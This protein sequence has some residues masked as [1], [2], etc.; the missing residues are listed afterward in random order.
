MSEKTS[1]QKYCNCQKSSNKEILKSNISN[2]FCKKCGTILLKSSDGNICYPLH[3]K[4]KKKFIDFN[5]IEIIK[6]MKEKTEKDYPNIYNLYNL[7]N[8]TDETKANKPMRAINMYL[9]YRSSLIVNLQKMMKTFDYCDIVFYQTLFYL[10]TY[11]SHD[12][13]LEMSEKSIFY[14][15]VGYF[16][17]SLKSKE[18]D[19]YEPSFDSFYDIEKGMFLSP[20]KI[21]LYEV[22]CLKRI[23]YNIFNYSSYDW[24]MQ[25]I[26]IGIVFNSEVDNTNEIILI[27][28]HRHSLINT[29]NKSVI[30]ILLN[31]TIKEAFFKYSPMHVAFSVIQLTREKYIK[32]SMIKPKL[33]FKLIE[34]YGVQ[35]S[36]YQDCYEELKKIIT[37]ED[38]K[39]NIEEKKEIKNKKEE[40]DMDQ[41]KRGSL[42]KSFIN[43]N[44]K[45]NI[46]VPN[47]MRSSNANVYIN[48]NELLNM[49]KEEKEINKNKENN[50]TR[51]IISI[52]KNHLSIDCSKNAYKRNDTLPL[53][54]INTSGVNKSGEKKIPNQKMSKV[55]KFLLSLE[56]EE[57]KQGKNIS[58]NK[59]EEGNIMN[60]IRLVEKK[61]LTSTKLPKINLD[62][63]ASNKAYKVEHHKD[64]EKTRKHY[65]LK[66]TNNNFEKK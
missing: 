62:E 3:Q 23:K 39:K 34:L 21:A 47:K 50:K 30:K 18:N 31:I 48:Q 29:I 63:I 64:G 20:S 4:Q 55:D 37:N 14:Y 28:G 44:M 32:E 41:R 6:S 49:T 27:K 15:L 19:I 33:F 38:N 7:P 11:L 12:I 57:V 22:I 36:D 35:F 16:L 26:A 46:Y 8:F 25:L 24:V 5:P 13:T 61:G 43:F 42:D 59:L 54:N 51:N 9:R 17:I 53:I 60:N 52:N 40:R 2:S 1:Q 56:K 65:K 45:K 58:S 10:D 66:T